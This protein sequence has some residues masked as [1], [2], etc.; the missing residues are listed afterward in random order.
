MIFASRAA[1]LAASLLSAALEER[2]ES[3]LGA[4]TAASVLATEDPFAEA[5]GDPDADPDLAPGL[6]VLKVVEN[7]PAAA[8]GL[9]AGDRLLRLDGEEL[10]VPA[11]L[12]ALVA[13]SAAGTR[14]RLDVRRGDRLVELEALTVPRLVPRAPPAEGRFV[15][16]RR[17]GVIVRP[18]EAGRALSLGLAP[19]D[20]VVVS[21]L[22]AGGP[23]AAASL[24]AGDAILEVRGAAVHGP[25]D[26]LALAARLEPGAEVE[27]VIARARGG[28]RERLAVETRSPERFV[29]YF[30]LPGVVI[31]EQDRRQDETTFGLILNIFKYTRKEKRSSYRFLWLIRLD[32]GENETLEEVAP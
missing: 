4:H 32:F 3:Y 29:A 18:L 6:E 21:R 16:A 31:Y 19:G 2:S 9:Q 26:F 23:A 8:A 20:G 17:L 14:L 27:I 1:L 25:E 11:H 5:D 15:E 22:L 13:R 7:S 10:R 28:E 12:D 24:A 30:H